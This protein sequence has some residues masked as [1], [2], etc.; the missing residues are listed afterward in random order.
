MCARTYLPRTRIGFARRFPL[1]A[2]AAIPYAGI[3]ARFTP[4]RLF[5]ME[6]PGTIRSILEAKGSQVW[7]TTRDTLVYDALTLMGEKNVGALVAV[8]GDEVVG[9]VSERDYSRKVVLRGRTSR[10]TRV[11]E[12]LSQP[13]ITVPPDH[14]IGACMALMTLHRIRHLPVIENDRLAGLVSMGDLVKYVIESQQQTIS[15]LHGYITGKYPG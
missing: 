6:V 14:G 2:L 3:P 10:E 12:I 1:D 8:E 5:I 11:G 7:T 15:Q 9:L 13:V 4:I